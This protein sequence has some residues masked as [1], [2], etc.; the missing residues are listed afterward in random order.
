MKLISKGESLT[1]EFKGEEKRKISDEEIIEAVVCMANAEGGYI[2]IGVE[3]DHRIT[4]ARPRRGKQLDTAGLAP[5]I[6]NRI[7]PSLRVE[8]Q[9]IEHEDRE[10]VVI[11]VPHS[12]TPVGSSKGL[13]KKR[14]ID[15]D[16]RP[17]C[18]PYTPYEHISD[19]TTRGQLDYTAQPLTDIDSTALDPLEIERLFSN[20]RKH[21]GDEVL[22]DMPQMDGLKALG[23]LKPFGKK[24]NR[25]VP[26]IGGLLL[27]GKKEILNEFLPTHEIAFQVIQGTDI[28]INE[29]FKEP[30][31]KT[32]ETIWNYFNARNEIRSQQVGLFR[33]DIADYDEKAFREALNNAVLHRDYS[34]LGTV[35]IQ[36][37]EDRIQISNP[38]GF[39]R[40]VTPKNILTVPP[41][42]RNPLLADIFKRI[43]L[44]ERS[45]RGVD[46]IF[47]GQIKNGRIPPD[48][49]QSNPEVVVLKIPGGPAKLE[50]IQLLIEHANRYQSPLPFESMLALDAIYRLGPQPMKDLSNILQSQ[51][52]EVR[53]VIQGLIDYG[54]VEKKGGGRGMTYILSPALYRRMEKPFAYVRSY[55]FEGLQQ[56][57][58]V[59][60]VIE[61][62]GKITRGEV[63]ELCKITKDQAYRLLNKLKKE[64]KIVS[65]GVRRAT[66]Y[67]PSK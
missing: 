32:L 56:E 33:V 20:I 43:G 61:S 49:S 24:K 34:R 59:L 60:K 15:S 8:A 27:L 3:D 2:F 28:Q 11:E 39:M 29:F 38:G 30:L 44:V 17:A 54:Y 7:I 1:V 63:M 14:I 46:L 65:F 67:E 6:Y 16:G 62:N 10:V 19:L 37:H 9:V 41:T 4:G 13:Y 57:Q 18:I 5:M 47:T 35:Y 53:E 25:Y 36:W 66:W 12:K 21:R 22:L 52:E 26:T 42:P 23:I 51:P 55:G 64:G 31:L 48:Y 45:G 58:M 50:F 40:G